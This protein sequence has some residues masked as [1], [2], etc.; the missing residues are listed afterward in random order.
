MAFIR[1][2]SL[3][4]RHPTTAGSSITSITVRLLRG[5]GFLFGGIDNEPKMSYGYFLEPDKK[6]GWTA[7]FINGEMTLTDPQQFP[8]LCNDKKDSPSVTIPISRSYSNIEN[9]FMGIHC[10][11]MPRPGIPMAL[12]TIRMAVWVLNSPPTTWIHQDNT[13]MDSDTW[14]PSASK[15]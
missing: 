12:L 3:K 15:K 8:A 14:K 5:R 1:F 6:G 2:L 11:A 9:I 4:T 10:P 7:I 13:L